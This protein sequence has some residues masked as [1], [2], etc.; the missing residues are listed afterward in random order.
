MEFLIYS[1][2]TPYAA[3]YLLFIKRLWVHIPGQLNFFFH[4][5]TITRKSTG[6]TKWLFLLETPFGYLQVWWLDKLGRLFKKCTIH[7]FVLHEV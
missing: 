6:K 5:D 3:H 2:C 1:Y 7:I 4:R